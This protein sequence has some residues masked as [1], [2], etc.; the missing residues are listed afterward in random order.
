[1]SG[2]AAVGNSA[3]KLGSQGAA[4]RSRGRQ[5]LAAAARTAWSLDHPVLTGEGRRLL[6][7]RANELRTVT[8]PALRSV[9]NDPDC[10]ENTFAVYMYAQAELRQLDATLAD[11]RRISTQKCDPFMVELGDLVILEFLNKPGRE[12]N[13]S[14]R[15]GS[16]QRFLLVHPVEGTLDDLR[17]SATSPLARAPAGP[18]DRR[19][20]TGGR[21]RRRVP[22]SDPGRH[23]AEREVRPADLG[24]RLRRR[25][26]SCAEL[27]A[28]R[29]PALGRQHQRVRA[30]A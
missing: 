8:P 16:V 9:V 29:R 11:A 18:G 2:A 4:T 22:S 21:P 12:G 30:R 5:L 20:R 17:I 28:P 3:T 27:A 15:G 23:E 24:G 14:R 1:M 10:D 6:E 19:R 25:I 7:A 26:R 13:G